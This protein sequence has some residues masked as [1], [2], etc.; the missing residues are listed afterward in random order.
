MTDYTE[1]HW[2]SSGLILIDMQVD[3]AEGGSS[4][5][6]GT[7]AVAPN[8]AR[9]SAAFR[10]AG[11]PVVHVVRL[12]DPAGTDVDLTRREL[13][14]SG[15]RI[16][17]PRSAGS[18][19]IAGLAASD[20]PSASLPIDP[21]PLL[22]GRPLELRD[23]EIVLFKPRWGAFYRTVLETWLRERD[24]DT[25]VVAGCNLPNC[26]RATLFE[27]SERDFRTVLAPDSASQTSPQRLDDLAAIGVNLVPADTIIKRV[28]SPAVGVLA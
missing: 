9:L 3:F 28:Q 24:V 20:D 10:A 12:Y 2:Q 22:A 18:A 1:P 4:P 25:V 17:A 26:P 8:V 21:E 23:H 5:I 7:A 16:V 15:A 19:I 6:A 13:I 11:R 27:A 14:E